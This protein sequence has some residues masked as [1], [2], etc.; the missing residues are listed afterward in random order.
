MINDD[1]SERNLPERNS[2]LVRV[3]RSLKCELSTPDCP[4]K[5]VVLG[6]AHVF[7]FQNS[8]LEERMVNQTVAE[9]QNTLIF[10]AMNRISQPKREVELRAFLDQQS[11]TILYPKAY[12]VRSS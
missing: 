8:M 6:A 1:Y 2:H 4:K 9:Q 12:Y 10:S 7:D 5:F 11:Y 3:L